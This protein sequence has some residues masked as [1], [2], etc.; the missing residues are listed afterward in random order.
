M[1]IWKHAFKK[2]TNQI[3]EKLKDIIWI[4]IQIVQRWEDELR[5]LQENLADKQGD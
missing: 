1:N 5:V 3:N 2:S 4:P